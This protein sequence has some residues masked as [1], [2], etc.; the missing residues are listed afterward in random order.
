MQNSGS[1]SLKAGGTTQRPEAEMCD[2]F[3]KQNDL[4]GWN[5]LSY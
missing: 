1:R 4:S 5:T 3:E 2:M